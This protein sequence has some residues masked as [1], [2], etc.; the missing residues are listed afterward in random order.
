[1]N[2]LPLNLKKEFYYQ[3]Y[4]EKIQRIKLFK[5]T[6]NMYPKNDG[7][8]LDRTGI[9]L[10]ATQFEIQTF[11]PG[12]IIYEADYIAEKVFFIISGQVELTEPNNFFKIQLSEGD[13]FGEMEFFKGLTRLTKAQAIKPKKL[14]QGDLDENQPNKEQIVELFS[15]NRAQFE[16]FF[17][18]IYSYHGRILR[19][20]AD[21]KLREFK[22]LV[23]ERL[24]EVE[25]MDTV[26]FSSS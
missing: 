5:D 15:M 22:H 24:S 6:D 7:I 21:R 12:Q 4:E 13:T 2:F 11:K 26:R 17:A 16:A 3:M 8:I 23:R 25:D 19:K 20:L 1:M 9:L 18:N 10:F 14:P